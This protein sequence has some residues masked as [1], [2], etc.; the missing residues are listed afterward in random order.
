ML[1]TGPLFFLLSVNV[2]FRTPAG[3]GKARPTPV[4][5]PRGV[6]PASAG[7]KQ[8]KQRIYTTAAVVDFASANRINVEPSPQGPLPRRD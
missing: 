8:G 6:V 3:C 5:R 4:Q 2:M 1:S 7:L